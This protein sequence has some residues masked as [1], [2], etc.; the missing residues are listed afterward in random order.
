MLNRLKF[1]PLYL[2]I[3][4][5][6]VVGLIPL[7]WYKDGFIVLGHDVGFPLAPIEHFLD[8]LFTWTDRVGPFGSNSIHQIAGFFI[9][10]LEAILSGLGFSLIWVQKLTFIFW[11]TL[12][13]LTMYI[14]LR[15]LYPKKEDYP[16][17]LAGSLFY[18]MNHYLLQA[19]TIAER[20][21]FSIVAAIP[22]VILIIIRVIYK[23]GTIFS[24]SIFFALTLFFLNGGEGI[25]LWGG[26][27]VAVL[28]IT[29][30][31]FFLSKE[32]LAS[33]LRRILSFAL[34]SCIL[35][36]LLNAYWLYPF[37]KSYD[38][39]VT[40]RIESR[41]G[42]AGVIAWSQTVSYNTSWINLLKLQGVPDWYDN[43]GHPYADTFFSNPLL[44]FL[45][46]LFP[47]VALVGLLKKDEKELSSNIKTA[48][49]CLLLVGVPLSAGSHPPLGGL[50]E[51]ALANIPGF[52]MFRSGFFKFGV[53]IWLVYSLFI[54]IGLK[55]LID[56]FKKRFR[57]NQKFIP[58]LFL[59]LFLASLFIYNYPF[60]TGSFFNWSKE[61]SNRVK[62]PDYIFE[63]KR[64][65]DKNKFS[66]RTLLLPNADLRT[67][68]IDYGW[69]YFSVVVLQDSLGRKSN[70]INGN[71]AS[72]DEK[73][74][75]N[76]IYKQYNLYGNSDL[77]KF[78]GIDS[79]V[80]Q[81]DFIS[82]SHIENTLT[83]LVGN[84]RNS[85][86]F[87]FLKSI[88][89]WDFFN[90][91]KESLPV[92][93]SPSTINYVSASGDNLYL[94]GNLPDI[95]GDTDSFFWSGSNE[96][97][98]AE[99]EIFNRYTIEAACADCP[100]QQNYPIYLAASKILIPGNK[101]YEVNR[102]I[103]KI[104]LELP[105]NPSSKI[106]LILS[107][108]SRLVGN[109]GLLVY[110]KEKEN[111][112]K[113]AAK[114]L[115]QN[116]SEIENHV[117]VIKNRQLRNDEAKKINF[118]LNFFVSYIS[119]WKTTTT[120]E[121]L[122]AD[123]NVL[124]DK[125]KN[126]LQKIK[127]DLPEREIE[128][129]DPNQ[130]KYNLSLPKDGKYSLYLYLPSYTNESVKI[131]VKGQPLILSQINKDWYGIF[132]LSY[133][134]SVMDLNID[135]SDLVTPKVAKV[136]NF[137]L[138]KKEESSCKDF[139]LNDLNPK[140][141]YQISFQHDQD[142]AKFSL[143]LIETNEQLNIDNK[144]EALYPKTALVDGSNK[145]YKTTVDYIPSAS[146]NDLKI[147][148]CLSLEIEPEDAEIYDFS[149]TA[150]PKKPI[151][152]ATLNNDLKLSSPDIEYL[153][154]NQ[155]KYL[156]KVKEKEGDFVLNFNSRFDKGWRLREVDYNKAVN[157]FYGEQRSFMGGKVIE[158][159]RKDNHILTDL[160]FNT[161]YGEKLIPEFKLNGF[162]N[163]WFISDDQSSREKIYLL[164]YNYQNDF[165]KAASIS[166]VSLILIVGFYIFKY[167]KK[168]V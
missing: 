30:V 107:S 98:T 155:T 40:Q 54:A 52:V 97:S 144:V 110:D 80:L 43:P 113:V 22:I 124:D 77:I 125:L 103:E 122:A 128:D 74:L 36:V 134:K 6:L 127:Q 81:N 51:F 162:S 111:S 151:I 123:L 75:I 93:Y 78:T 114:D 10:G 70:V 109:L 91:S 13:G 121:S 59:A 92:I 34:L 85:N 145:L 28:V 106:N 126:Y 84:F 108:S 35:L 69:S 157:F 101:I 87:T 44:I 89:Q 53:L 153:A 149:I 136:N 64:E 166:F 49:L 105:G 100:Q 24:N 18:M 57:E 150:I 104:W 29:T 41:W 48:F 158:Y 73:N 119:Q 17:R 47:A 95:K 25:P 72:A 99:K 168:K 46:I 154:L 7:F 86:D 2:E 32:K 112:A 12:P 62:I 67:E 140:I 135:K 11:F 88:G 82:P 63:A 14:L 116:L 117:E 102:Y 68:Y 142:I 156:V 147:S 1:N 96:T 4:L 146:A 130:Y 79:A 129:A 160:V 132:N 165:Y 21:K 8:R 138:S 163:T 71:S 60:F 33:K 20:T 159:L 120:S 5:I 131:L 39:T 55:L 141:N 26:L 37:L 90:Y 66:T 45:G 152:F 133:V 148:I 164:E 118:F 42:I 137:K 115:A 50:Y 15:Y 23:K 19:W 38:Q 76:S 27:V 167:A 83:E 9:H 143:Q 61:H 65:L 56:L 161:S 94:I 3:M 139:M 16:L 31:L 58:S